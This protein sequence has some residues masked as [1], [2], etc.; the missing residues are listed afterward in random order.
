M[1]LSQ[2]ALARAIDIPPQRI[3]EIIRGLRPVTPDLDLRI[4]RYFGVSEGMF[5]GLQMDYRATETAN[6][7]K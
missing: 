7:S 5:L 2:R 3:S 4:A 6:C 1:G